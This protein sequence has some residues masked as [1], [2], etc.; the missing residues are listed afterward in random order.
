MAAAS[1]G[2]RDVDFGT[3]RSPSFATDEHIEDEIIESLEILIAAGADINSRIVD[4][5]SRTA[6]IARPSDLTD[7]EGQT[8]L[9]RVAGQGWQRV[10]EFMLANGAK[11]DV[12]DVLGRS[13]RDMALGRFASGA[14]VYEDLAALLEAAGG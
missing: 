13:A 9:F 5:Y 12:A 11:A 10:T 8:A 7:R 3:N 1:I 4:T 2:V 6:R 14:P